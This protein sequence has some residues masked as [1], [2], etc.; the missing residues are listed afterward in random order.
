M[1]QWVSSIF[2]WS[3]VLQSGRKSNILE[4][5]AIFKSYVLSL[6]HSTAC[7]SLSPRI[8]RLQ[9][10]G[11]ENIWFIETTMDILIINSSKIL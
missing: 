9:E 4:V 5:S 7:S 10:M 2:S 1:L 8:T 6:L 11:K 3:G